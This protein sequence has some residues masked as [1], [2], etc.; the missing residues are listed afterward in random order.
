VISPDRRLNPHAH[1]VKKV[2][3]HIEVQSVDALKGIF[4][5]KNKYFFKTLSGY[6]LIVRLLKNGEPVFD[7]T[8]HSL[9]TAPQSS[10]QME[11][12]FPALDAGAEYLVNFLFVLKEDEG[13]LKKGY[14]TAME[15]LLV[16]KGPCL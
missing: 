14:E 5:V 11:I 4:T 13:I 6:Q 1:E 15:Q 3:Q 9:A 2:Y 8:I 7:Q 10:E 16:Q 12:D